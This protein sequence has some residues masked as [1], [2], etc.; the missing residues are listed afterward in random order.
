MH[1]RG[2]RFFYTIGK[3]YTQTRYGKPCVFC[4]PWTKNQVPYMFPA[5]FLVLYWNLQ[6]KVGFFDFYARYLGIIA[7]FWRIFHESECKKLIPS[8]FFIQQKVPKKLNNQ[9]KSTFGLPRVQASHF[10]DPWIPAD[11]GTWLFLALKL[12]QNSLFDC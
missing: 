5:Q 1:F 12:S 10:G 4:F 2:L 11:R 6:S 8:Q 3:L 9:R 7:F